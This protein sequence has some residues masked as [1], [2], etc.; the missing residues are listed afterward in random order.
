MTTIG[1]IIE[2]TSPRLR[3]LLT[4]A[5]RTP[6]SNGTARRAAFAPGALSAA[7]DPLV[8]AIVKAREE[9]P[10][11]QRSGA[12]VFLRLMPADQDAWRAL[13]LEDVYLCCI[14]GILRQRVAA[15]RRGLRESESGKEK[16]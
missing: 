6:Q 7:S 13:G 1:E 9:L 14:A 5:D 3:A 4:R 11:A 2:T 15:A 12:R 8:T 10:A 16:V